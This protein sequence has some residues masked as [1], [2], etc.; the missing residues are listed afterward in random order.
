MTPAEEQDEGTGERGDRHLG[1]GDVGGLGV[2]DVEHPLQLPHRLHPVG[3]RPEGPEPL[4][5]CGDLHTRRADGERGGERIGD[6]VIAQ[7]RELDAGQKLRRIE[8]E[9]AGG[10]IVPG[11]GALTNRKAEVPPGDARHH[12]QRLGIVGVGDPDRA[13]PGVAK[14]E[15]LVAIVVRERQISIEMIG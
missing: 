6:V 7:E 11:V 14:E 12:R 5:E 3:E 9:D 4:V 2:V 10:A 8:P 15:P 1:G 13:G